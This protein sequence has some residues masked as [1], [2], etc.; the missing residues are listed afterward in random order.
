MNIPT[1]LYNLWAF[2]GSWVPARKDTAVSQTPTHPKRR[3]TRRFYKDRD[4]KSRLVER[5]T[6]TDTDTEPDRCRYTAT[7]YRNRESNFIERATDTDTEV[8]PDRC[9][10]T[11]TQNPHDHVIGIRELNRR[12]RKR[13]ATLTIDLILWQNEGPRFPVHALADTGSTTSLVSKET[14]DKDGLKYSKYR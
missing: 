9:Y 13:T 11:A 1:K 3:K 12:P 2:L 6:D 5:V 7:H 10:N 14:A 4:R 8:E